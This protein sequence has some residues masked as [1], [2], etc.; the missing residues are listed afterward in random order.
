M[1]KCKFHD[2]DRFIICE[3]NIYTYLNKV[4]RN[5]Y[6]DVIRMCINQSRSS[7]VLI[8]TPDKYD[9]SLRIFMKYFMDVMP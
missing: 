7:D 6:L 9:I 5:I 4:H 1:N 2:S 8:H 3:G